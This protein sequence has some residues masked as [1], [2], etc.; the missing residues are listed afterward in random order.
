MNSHALRQ[1]RQLLKR[2]H[3]FPV[4]LSANL[5]RVRVEGR[6]NTQP[7]LL[8]LPISQQRGAKVTRTYQEGIIGVVPAEELL[9][10]VQ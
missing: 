8:E 4:D 6:H 2:Q 1:R 5:L 7:K 10:L 9:D 3:N